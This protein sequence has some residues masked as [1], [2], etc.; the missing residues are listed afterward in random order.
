[1]D[2]ETA[3]D[4]IVSG[5]TDAEVQAHLEG[6]AACRGEFEFRDQVGAALAAMPRAAAPEGLLNCV[7]AEISGPAATRETA[8]PPRQLALR[9]W[10]IAGLSLLCLLLIGLLP[11]LLA[12]WFPGGFTG[13]LPSLGS[14]S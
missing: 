11:A 2:C 14:S 7:L 9:A 13:T 3:R 1:M 8:V 10:E 12:R 6:C 4:K 5:E